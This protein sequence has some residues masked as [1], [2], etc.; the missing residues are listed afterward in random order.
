MNVFSRMT[1]TRGL[2]R[3]ISQVKLLHIHIH[4]Q[5]YVI[6]GRPKWYSIEVY[7]I[8]NYCEGNTWKNAASN[9]FVKDALFQALWTNMLFKFSEDDVESKCYCMSFC[10]KYWVASSM[11]LHV[12]PLCFIS[13]YMY[14]L[15]LGLHF[16][17]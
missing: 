1:I 14:D 4:V 8:T 16:L 2:A 17:F 13:V 9:I 7:T 10:L 3:N 11:L 6:A 12:Y 5:F 15:I